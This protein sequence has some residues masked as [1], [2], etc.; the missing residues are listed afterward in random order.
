M[1]GLAGASSPDHLQKRYDPISLIGRL[2][3]VKKAPTTRIPDNPMPAIL[4]RIGLHDG[5]GRQVR[6]RPVAK[7]A[8]A[9][10][11]VDAKALQAAS[12][13]GCMGPVAQWRLGPE[14]G[15]AGRPVADPS[16]HR[17]AG[18]PAAIRR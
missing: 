9:V 3:R 14:D 4:P 15:L 2:A 17:H 1:G 12:E 7:G 8:E 6:E 5:A 16:H 18:N 10:G 11:R 13:I